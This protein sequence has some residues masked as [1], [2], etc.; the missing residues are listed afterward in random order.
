MIQPATSLPVHNSFHILHILLISR[1]LLCAGVLKL[2][3]PERTEPI[4]LE[5]ELPVALGMDASERL[6]SHLGYLVAMLHPIPPFLNI[7]LW[8]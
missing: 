8:S 4:S 2:L 7:L 1:L 3:V 5:G 6:R